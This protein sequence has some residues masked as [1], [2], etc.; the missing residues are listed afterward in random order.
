MTFINEQLYEKPLM[1]N[2]SNYEEPDYILSSPMPKHI[3]TTIFEV[4]LSNIEILAKRNRKPKF[5]DKFED[6]LIQTS[7]YYRHLKLEKHKKEMGSDIL[8]YKPGAIT[9]KLLASNDKAMQRN[10]KRIRELL[11]DHY[12]MLEFLTHDEL[13]SLMINYYQRLTN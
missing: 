8:G 3:P 11:K 10:E 1:K 5:L 4:K 2:K 9:F 6:G 7:D 12:L 13:L